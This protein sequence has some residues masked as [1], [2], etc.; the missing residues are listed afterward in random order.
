MPFV[1]FFLVRI[2]QMGQKNGG[3]PRRPPPCR[4]KN[5]CR[6]RGDGGES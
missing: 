5:G 4:S 3:M 6:G 1:H 2:S